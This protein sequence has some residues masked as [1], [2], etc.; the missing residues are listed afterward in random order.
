[1][2]FAITSTAACIRSQVARTSKSLH[3]QNTSARRRGRTATGWPWRPPSPARAPAAS[4]APQPRRSPAAPP[5]ALAGQ[6]VATVLRETATPP[7]TNDSMKPSW[8]A[9]G[10]EGRREVTI[11][12]AGVMDGAKGRRTAEVVPLTSDPPPVTMRSDTCDVAACSV[13][14]AAVARHGR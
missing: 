13:S 1:M 2:L 8:S 12:A 3:T 14:A 11:G 9:T 5:E 7:R 6:A 10:A 4:L